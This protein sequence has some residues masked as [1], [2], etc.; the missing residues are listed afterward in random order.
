MIT[1]AKYFSSLL[2]A[3]GHRMIKAGS[4]LGAVQADQCAPFGDDSVPMQGLDIIYAETAS[5]ELPVIIG[6]INTNQ[7]AAEGEK[8]F[9]SMKRNEDGTYSQAFY[10]WMKSDGTFEMGGT[11]DNAIRYAKL[12]QGLQLAIDRINAELPKIAAGIATG[13]GTYVPTDITLDISAAKIEE[14]KTL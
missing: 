9:F 7:K 11:D 4:M 6:C 5:D 2:D 14:I 12:N 1:L 3:V 13:G 10:T 8:R